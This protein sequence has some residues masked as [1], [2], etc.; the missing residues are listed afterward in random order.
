MQNEYTEYLFSQ[1]AVNI[2]H[3]IAVTKAQ[4]QSDLY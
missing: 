4:L 3:G 2:M 1:R